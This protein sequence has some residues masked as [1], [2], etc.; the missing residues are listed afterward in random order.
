M[1]IACVLFVATAL[2]AGCEDGPE[3]IFQPNTG[4]PT[5][6]NGYADDNPF[7][8]EIHLKGLRVAQ[9]WAVVGGDHERA[10]RL[11]A[12][13][14]SEGA[15]HARESQRRREPALLRGRQVDPGQPGGV[16]CP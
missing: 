5:D 4:N 13:L 14:A 11:G 2:L 3:Q 12:R 6:Q 1:R 10:A 16:M 9:Y 15:R 8:Q 7:V